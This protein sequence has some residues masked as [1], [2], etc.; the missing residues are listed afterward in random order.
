MSSKAWTCVVVCLM[1]EDV[2]FC[3]CLGILLVYVWAS[4]TRSYW[5]GSLERVSGG[6][7]EWKGLG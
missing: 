1:C 2:W 7:E 5:A 6:L 4:G 3:M